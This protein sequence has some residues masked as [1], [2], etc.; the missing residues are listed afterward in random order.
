MHGIVKTEPV[1]ILSNNTS[2]KQLKKIVR[3]SQP[4]RSS[5]TIFRITVYDKMID[6][7]NAGKN[8]MAA[9]IKP[10]YIRNIN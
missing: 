6:Q 1:F 5:T 9:H 3:K 2:D 4:V 10:Y 8:K 7:S